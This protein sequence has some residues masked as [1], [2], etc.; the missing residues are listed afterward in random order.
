MKYEI[1]RTNFGAVLNT[2]SMQVCVRYNNTIWRMR[3]PIQLRNWANADMPSTQRPSGRKGQS[4]NKRRKTSLG[5]GLNLSAAAAA[6]DTAA[7]KT[8]RRRRWSSA[9]SLNQH[10]QQLIQDE[11]GKRNEG[12]HQ[13]PRPSWLGRED[14]FGD[15][16]AFNVVEEPWFW[17]FFTL[18]FERSLCSYKKWEDDKY[19]P[20]MKKRQKK[21]L[22]QCEL[23]RSETV[24]YLFWASLRPASCK[25]GGGEQSRGRRRS[26]TQDKYMGEEE[27]HL[28][29]PLLNWHHSG[30]RL[31]SFSHFPFF[32]QNSYRS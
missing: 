13:P 27:D 9:G 28:L 11:E 22:F 25:G 31:L 30:P 3:P 20:K 24:F 32:C 23:R 19:H 26:G 17:T 14:D 18:C 21:T 1:D 5:G 12:H 4:C 2:C 15:C 8:S 6:A 29:P 7:S 16:I 10:A